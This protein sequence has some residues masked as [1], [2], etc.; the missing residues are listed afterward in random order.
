MSWY[1][2]SKNLSLGALDH[3]VYNVILAPDFQCEDLEGFSA[4]QENRHL[5]D[6][7]S[8]HLPETSESL[9]WLSSDV[10]RKSS[11]FLPLPFTHKSYKSEKHAPTIQIHNAAPCFEGLFW[12]TSPTIDRKIQDLLFVM[13]A[14]H[15]S[16][17]MHLH[18]NWS[19][20]IFCR[21][22]KSFTH[23]LH[24][25]SSEVCPHFETRETP[26]EAEASACQ[27]AAAVAKNTGNIESSKPAKT[28]QKG[29]VANTSH[30]TKSF[31]LD[32]PKIHSI[33]HYPDSI[34]CFSTTDSYCTQ[35]GEQEHKCVK[36]FYAQTNKNQFEAQIAQQSSVGHAIQTTVEDEQLP[37]TN[38][39]EHHYISKTKQTPLNLLKW[40]KDHVNDPAVKFTGGGIGHWT[41][42]DATHSLQQ[43]VEE[44]FSIGNSSTDMDDS[45]TDDQDQENAS[46]NSSEDSSE[47]EDLSEEDNKEDE[48]ISEE[49]SDDEQDDVEL[50]DDSL[51]YA[52]L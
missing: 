51:G 21:L 6:E 49:E 22:T 2:S 25:F 50:L 24:I 52:V 27:K 34:Q 48:E 23:H 31:R 16:A 36:A 14:W 30:K 17:K 45:E 3:L 41:T 5:D 29:K 1:Y 12:R 15:A 19:L 18:T 32:I 7:A 20:G 26:N 10:W 42:R 4:V 13:A 28:V 46:N 43:D 11:V 37:P 35:I 39:E 40:V 9:P 33:V 47:D 8:D 38:P 44:G